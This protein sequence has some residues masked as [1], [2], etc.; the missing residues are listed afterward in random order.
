MRY[1]S[2]MG[3]VRS[4]GPTV[5]DLPFGPSASTKLY[6]DALRCNT[7]SCSKSCYGHSYARG[8]VV[9]GWALTVCNAS[10][11]T[12]IDSEPDDHCTCGDVDYRNIKCKYINTPTPLRSLSPSPGEPQNGGLSR[13][14]CDAFSHSPRLCVHQNIRS[15]PRPFR[16]ITT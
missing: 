1:Q 16:P 10:V 8:S 9:G 13:S 15:S 5:V 7:N 6:I 2:R 12:S 11:K 3:L 14:L 4:L